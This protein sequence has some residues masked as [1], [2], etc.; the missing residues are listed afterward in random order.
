MALRLRRGLDI[1]RSAITFA[2][3]EPLY[4]TDTKQ[5]YIGDGITPGGVQIG[6]MNN[7]IDDTAPQL[8]NDLDLNTYD[9]T[10]VGS[11]NVDGNLT[12]TGKVVAEFIEAD[13]RGSIFGNDSAVLVDSNNNALHADLYRSDGVKAV[14]FETGLVALDTTP[15]KALSDINYDL[16]E[17]GDVLSWNG[18]EWTGQTFGG[19]STHSSILQYV[20]DVGFVGTQ[21]LK[22]ANDDTIINIDTGYVNIGNQKL[23]ELKDVFVEPTSIT[24]NDVLTW[25]GNNW[26]H[27]QITIDLGESELPINALLDVYTTNPA[28]NDTLMWDGANFVNQPLPDIAVTLEELED[29]L[30]TNPKTPNDILAWDG[31]K[32]VNT[33]NQSLSELPDVNLT[34]PLAGDVLTYDG[35]SWTGSAMTGINSLESINPT[36]NDFLKYDGVGWQP[37]DIYLTDIFDVT[38]AAPN[39][40]EVLT[41]NGAQWINLP[42]TS[43]EP[44]DTFQGNVIG[45]D[46]SII[47]DATNNSITAI[48]ING[49]EVYANE[50]FTDQIKSNGTI[51]ITNNSNV[52]TELKVIGADTASVIKLARTSTSDLSSDSYSHGRLYFERQDSNGNTTT[53]I[54]DA[55][56]DS[57]NFFVD[58]TGN[59]S[60][61]AQISMKRNTSNQMCLG[62]NKFDPVAQVDVVGAIAATEYIQ[63][64]NYTTAERDAITAQSGMVIYNSTTNKFQGY[65]VNAWVDL[66]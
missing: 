64:G 40:G 43:Y 3:G 31:D 2:E 60:P 55:G 24:V 56:N 57:F 33:A 58:P 59:F 19:N 53:A 62:V 20:V 66:S 54:M 11:I 46:S 39:F 10:G 45:F 29:V 5:L 15:A 9:I 37:V 32:W 41:W 47:V 34:N 44:M 65:S 28:I 26:T 7:L 52:R 1:E 8:G 35:T 61:A 18:S 38:I 22:A 23:E 25:D 13:Y 27:R 63:F 36:L 51:Q 6:G 42:P 14:D 30:I 48:T 49:T 50:V 21:L 4:T 17:I 16:P 12:I